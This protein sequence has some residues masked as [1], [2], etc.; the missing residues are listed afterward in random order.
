MSRVREVTPKVLEIRTQ[1]LMTEGL[2]RFSMTNTTEYGMSRFIRYCR[3]M[4][5]QAL[6]QSAERDRRCRNT[7]RI[8]ELQSQ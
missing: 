8:S 5:C 7:A 3:E 6:N 1:D 4:T 2:L